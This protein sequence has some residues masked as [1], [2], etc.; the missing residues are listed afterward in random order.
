MRTISQTTNTAGLTR[1]LQNELRQTINE[2]FQAERKKRNTEMYGKFTKSG[3]KRKDEQN[4]NGSTPAG[5]RIA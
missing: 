3:G 1:M 2:I 5:K 4:Q